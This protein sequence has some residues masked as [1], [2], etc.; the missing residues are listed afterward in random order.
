MTNRI[1]V[2][3][4]VIDTISAYDRGL[5]YGDGIFET[6]AVRA[7]KPCLWERHWSRLQAGYDALNLNGPNES[8]WLD[9]IDRLVKPDTEAVIKLMLTRGASGRGYAP[10]VEACV[11]RI[12]M[13]SAM[14]DYPATWH[15]QGVRVRWC[16]QRLG[17]NMQL[18]QIKHLNRLEQVMARSEWPAEIADGNFAEGLMLNS[19]GYVVEGVS[20]NVFIVREQQLIT[21]DLTA[22]GVAGVMR[23]EVLQQAETLGIVTHIAH[24]TPDDFLQ[25]D[26]V[27]ITNSLIGVW[28]VRELGNNHYTV[29]S[30]SSCIKETIKEVCLA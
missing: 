14:P 16:E 19:D 17:R 11:T 21:P 13:L 28:P 9:D 15:Q 29:G 8:Q 2:N 22:A 24:L 7:G 1:L 26:E 27:F 6:I 3:G 4:E 10:S 18:A 12:A 23:A 20:S 30:V 25:A 5:H